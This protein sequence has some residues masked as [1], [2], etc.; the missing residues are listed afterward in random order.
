MSSERSSEE[1]LQERLQRLD[2]EEWEVLTLSEHFPRALVNLIAAEPVQERALRQRLA[3]GLGEPA[4]RLLFSGFR[5]MLDDLRARALIDDRGGRIQ[6]GEGFFDRLSALDRPKVESTPKIEKTERPSRSRLA[7]EAARLQERTPKLNL[8][9]F[10]AGRL[11]RFFV[12]LDGIELLDV[13][14]AQRLNL[15]PLEFI[16]FMRGVETLDLAQ[17]KGKIIQLKTKG[18]AIAELMGSARLQ[19]LETL[20]RELRTLEAESSRVLSTEAAAI[21]EG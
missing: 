19:R 7:E 11:E 13:Q 18:Q 14:L 1:S 3:E 21:D 12:S 16:G 2:V 5:S 10:N 4:R 20:V 6:L 17:Q 8:Q 9:L 15:G